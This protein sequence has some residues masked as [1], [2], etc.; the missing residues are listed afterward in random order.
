MKTILTIILSISI[1]MQSINISAI[2]FI[3]IHEILDHYQKHN[4]L[5][6]DSFSSFIK[7]HY[8][9]DV[10][11]HLDTI[12]KT[13]SEH[14]NEHHK[15]PKKSNSFKSLSFVAY[16]VDDCNVDFSFEYHKTDNFYYT[17]RLLNCFLDKLFQPPQ[18][19]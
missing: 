6:Q 4:E 19:V 7:K 5:Y 12:D 14:Q 3:N 13:D 10:S 8:Q 9:E 15:L 16:F 17:P 18:L 2:D 1:F 11:N